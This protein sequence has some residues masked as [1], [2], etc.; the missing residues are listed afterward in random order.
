MRLSLALCLSV[1][2]EWGQDADF[3]AGKGNA[4]LADLRMERV[5]WSFCGTW[6]CSARKGHR[7]DPSV[8]FGPL[9]WGAMVGPS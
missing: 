1:A 7:W 9:K 2:E 8:E 3:V 5:V 6:E 4:G